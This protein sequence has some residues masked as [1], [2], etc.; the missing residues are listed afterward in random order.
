MPSDLGMLVRRVCVDASA[1][2]K[3]IGEI[4]VPQWPHA[5]AKLARRDCPHGQVTNFPMVSSVR[6][7]VTLHF[8]VS[9]L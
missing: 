9:R 5:K 6:E 4:S 8:V 7:R 2:P 1:L 3:R